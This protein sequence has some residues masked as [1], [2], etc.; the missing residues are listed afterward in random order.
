MTQE[1]V[2]ELMEKPVEEVI[3]AT[4]EELSDYSEDMETIG[5]NGTIDKIND[6]IKEAQDTDAERISLSA[7][8]IK[9]NRNKKRG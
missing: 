6:E 2:K 4:R 5:L 1:Q 7:S 8:G 3:E 9:G